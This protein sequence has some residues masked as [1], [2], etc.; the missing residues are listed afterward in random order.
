MA[1]N[2]N[3]LEIP[4][5][6]DGLES[7]DLREFFT[8]RYGQ[9]LENGT[10]GPEVI[11]LTEI[12]LEGTKSKIVQA[13]KSKLYAISIRGFE[14]LFRKDSDLPRRFGRQV[15][16]FVKEAKQS[17][18]FFTSDE[19]PK[20]GLSRPETRIINEHM[21]KTDGD[22]YLIVLCAYPKDQ[23]IEILNFVV[24]ILKQYREKLYNEEQ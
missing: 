23:S 5:I 8:Q 6:D 24:E 10:P 3:E 1:K 9:N 19:L 14:G 4:F 2:D 12:S 11:S 16:D 18:G 22:G 20:Y 21:G 15:C 17:E 13:N 7:E